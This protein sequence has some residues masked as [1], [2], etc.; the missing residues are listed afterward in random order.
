MTSPSTSWKLVCDLSSHVLD[1]ITRLGFNNM[2]PVQVA[3]IPV[4]MRNKDVCVEAVTGSGKTLAFVVPMIEMLMKHVGT[5][6]KH[7]VGAVIVSPTR[8]L[9]SQIHEVVDGFLDDELCPFTSSLLIGGTGDIENDISDFTENGSNIIV[10]TPGR[11]SFALE[12]CMMLRSGVR[13]LEVLILDEA[14]RLLDLGFHKT[15]SSILGHLPK[16][17]RTGLFSATQTTEVE[18]L[19]KAGMRNPVKISVK[20]NFEFA[21]TNQSSTTKTPSTL[22]NYYCLCPVVAKF[23]SLMEFVSKRKDEKLLLFFSTCASVDYFGRGMKEI[24]GNEF[25]ILLLHGK[26]KKKR[27]EIFSK[28]RKLNS[29]ILVCTD[30]MA[31]GIDIPD[32]DWV[33]QYD[34]PSNASAFVHRCGR[35]ARVGRQGNALLFLLEAEATYVDFIEIN[36]KAPMLEYK[37]DVTHDT[38]WLSKLRGLSLKD[39]AAMDRGTRAFVSFVQSYAK[40]QCNLIFRVKDLNFGELATSFGLLKIPKMPEIKANSITGFKPANVDIDSIKFK[41]KAREKQRRLQ[42]KRKA[43]EGEKPKFVSKKAKAWS[44]IK[45]KKELRREKKEKRKKQKEKMTFDDDELEELRKDAQLVKKLKRKQISKTQY[46]DSVELDEQNMKKT[47]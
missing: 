43:E 1:T 33:L 13:S 12:K 8:E 41:D 44:G 27:L 29:G 21:S 4:F 14:D 6:K 28:F 40:H 23:N 7:H 39:R 47:L 5:M 30:V 26:I 24:L 20:E 3:T 38:D 9:A 42:N 25:T 11:I 37:E 15:L 35:T 22:Q 10:G 34:P 17:R 16:Q 32:V 18:Q 46:E 45:E 31:R 2:T 19:M 36:Q